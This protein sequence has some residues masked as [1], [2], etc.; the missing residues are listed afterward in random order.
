MEDLELK[1]AEY[2]LKLGC[3]CGCMTNR[4][5]D[6]MVMKLMFAEGTAGKKFLY[7]SGHR[8]TKHNTAVGGHIDSAH[9]YGEAVDIFYS[10]E[11]DCF[12]IIKALIGAG[13]ERIEVLS[14]TSAIGL[15]K[16]GAHIHVDQHHKMLMPWFHTGVYDRIKKEV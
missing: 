9:L 15:G 6:G 11:S 7:T 8:C 13:F 10:R 3:P 14:L 4:M 16:L 5:V 2:R 1:L 12:L